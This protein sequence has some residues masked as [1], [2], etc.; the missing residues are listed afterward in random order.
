VRDPLVPRAADDQ[1]VH[2]TPCPDRSTP[3][4]SAFQARPR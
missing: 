1:E 4:P 2:E 3:G